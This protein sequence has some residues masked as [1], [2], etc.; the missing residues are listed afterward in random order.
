MAYETVVEC[1]EILAA[2]GKTMIVGLGGYEQQR[3]EVSMRDKA[4]TQLR[5]FA[6]EIGASGAARSKFSVTEAPKQTDPVDAAIF[7]S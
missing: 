4:M 5:M 3:P 2:K 1:T 7:G 6:G